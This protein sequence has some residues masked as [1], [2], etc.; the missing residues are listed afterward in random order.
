MPCYPGS[1]RESTNSMQGGI[2]L[3]DPR[4]PSKGQQVEA[5]AIASLVQEPYPKFKIQL[6]GR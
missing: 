6:L 3:E 4:Q 2:V 1:G 5:D